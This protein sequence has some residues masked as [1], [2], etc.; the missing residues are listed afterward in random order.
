M[1]SHMRKGFGNPCKIQIGGMDSWY[2]YVN[3]ISEL[4]LNTFTSKNRQ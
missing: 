4:L 2:H 1:L 3:E